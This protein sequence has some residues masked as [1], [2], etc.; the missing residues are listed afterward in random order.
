MLNQNG[1]SIFRHVRKIVPG[2]QGSRQKRPESHMSSVF[3][4]RH[5]AVPNL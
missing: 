3:V 4:V 1:D 5:S 2:K